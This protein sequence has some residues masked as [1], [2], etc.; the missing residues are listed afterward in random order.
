MEQEQKARKPKASGRAVIIAAVFTG[1]AALATA[2]GSI[3]VGLD[4][5]KTAQ[6]GAEVH[7]AQLYLTL[8]EAIAKDRARLNRLR[9]KIERLRGDVR[10]LEVRLGM[11]RPMGGRRT[12]IEPLPD[13]LDIFLE[14]PD[15]LA[16][17]NAE[18]IE[19]YEDLENR[20]KEQ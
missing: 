16:F 9:V 13:D 11:H 8:R 15:T 5:G 10:V 19:A 17:P 6:K 12:M 1:L 20:V 4:Q 7:G 18:A 2:L 3:W 14:L